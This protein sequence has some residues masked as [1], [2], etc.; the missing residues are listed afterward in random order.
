MVKLVTPCPCVFFQASSAPAPQS[1][2]L[3]ARQLEADQSYWRYGLM[4]MLMMLVG[5]SFVGRVTA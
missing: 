5:E 4:L 2:R 1:T 3:H